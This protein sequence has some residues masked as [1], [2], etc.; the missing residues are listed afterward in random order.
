VV[1]DLR[2][3]VAVEVETEVNRLVETVVLVLVAVL[4]AVTVTVTVGVVD[5]VVVGVDEVDVEDEVLEA[6]GAPPPPCSCVV[7]DGKLADISSTNVTTS[8][9]EE[10]SEAKATTSM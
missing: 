9:G 10:A 1:V 8:D 2:V 6:G 7:V 4:V 3:S 5:R